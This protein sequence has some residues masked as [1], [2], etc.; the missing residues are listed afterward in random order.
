[1]PSLVLLAFAAPTAA[2]CAAEVFAGAVIALSSALWETTLQRGVPGESLSRVAS[3]D[4]MGSIAL[5]P[6]GLALVGPLMTFVGIRDTLLGSAAIVVA[7][8]AAILTVPAIRRVHGD[9]EPP[10]DTGEPLA[11]D[12]SRRTPG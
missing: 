8:T 6:I 3:Y 4:T 5:R 2:I 10:V 7:A 1:V 9:Q 12:I 11:V